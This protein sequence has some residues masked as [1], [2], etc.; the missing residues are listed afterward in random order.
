MPRGPSSLE[1]Y[2][3]RCDLVSK[4]HFNQVIDGPRGDAD[5]APTSINQ[6][7]LNFMVSEWRLDKNM[8]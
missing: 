7:F 3:Q 6:Y 1:P 8:G 5:G 2:S 4:I